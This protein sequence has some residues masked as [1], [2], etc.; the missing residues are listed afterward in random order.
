MCCLRRWSQPEWGLGRNL[1]FSNL[2]SALILSRVSGA[3]A[4]Q[5]CLQI[6]SPSPGDRVPESELPCWGFVVFLSSSPPPPRPSKSWCW[7]KLSRTEGGAC[8]LRTFFSLYWM[9]RKIVRLPFS[10]LS[11][12]ESNFIKFYTNLSSSWMS[13]LLS[14]LVFP[15]HFQLCG[16][17]EF[18]SAIIG[19]EKKK[20]NIFRFF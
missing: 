17:P 10:F 3:R 7:K 11:S 6:I 16:F 12:W 15:H 5:A 1:P 13:F 14:L 20:S 2:K 9:L 4:H 8:F 19:L 18:Y